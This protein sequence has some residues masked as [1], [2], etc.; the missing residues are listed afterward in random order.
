VGL[1]SAH[2]TR[3]VLAHC[4]EAKDSRCENSESVETP[5]TSVPMAAN[6]ERAALK[7]RISVGQ[8]KVNCETRRG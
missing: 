6:L 2:R 4:F 3:E 1:A 8:T 7:A 5:R